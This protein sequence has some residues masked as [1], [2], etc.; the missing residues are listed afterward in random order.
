MPTLIALKTLSLMRRRLGSGKKGGNAKG[1]HNMPG[2]GGNGKRK[3]DGGLDFVANT[4][5]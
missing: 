3:A 5:T 2:Q 4:S 1:Q